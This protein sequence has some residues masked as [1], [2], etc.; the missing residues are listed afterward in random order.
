MT[1][2][3]HLILGL[4]AAVFIAEPG[5]ALGQQ[6]DGEVSSAPAPPEPPSAPMAGTVITP[7]N[8]TTSSDPETGKQKDDAVVPTIRFNGSNATRSSAHDVERAA[9]SESVP[10][11]S[12]V[13]VAANVPAK[14]AEPERDSLV[15]LTARMVE[16]ADV[17]AES[18]ELAP[19]DIQSIDPCCCP[20]CRPLIWLA[21]V[22]ATFLWPD[23]N[24]DDAIFEFEDDFRDIDIS[25]SSHLDG[26]DSMYLT[27]RL[28][29]G[30]QG[31]NWGTNVRYW[32]LR[33]AGG[34]FDPTLDNESDDWSHSNFDWD[35]TPD[36]GFFTCSDLDAYTID[37]ELTR[38]FCLGNCAS[39]ASF[40]VRYGSVDVNNSI[41][42]VALDDD[43]R[44]VGY[45]RSNAYTRGTGVVMGLYGRKPLFP[46]SCV[47]WYYNARWSVMWGPTSTSAETFASVMVDGSNAGSVNG[48]STYVDDTLFIGEIQ[49]GLEWNY[50][51]QCLPA[52]AF[53]RTA[54]EYQRWDGGPGSSE[55]GSFASLTDTNNYTSTASVF[56]SAHSPQLDLLGL[57]FGTGLTW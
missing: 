48:A 49:L 22:E 10:R 11:K 39:Q 18:S 5:S 8:Q 57:T 44:H 31:C 32:H 51:L 26:V 13:I 40:G 47:H 37:W 9:V 17:P 12:E 25:H 42:G 7:S 35:A 14:S 21:G 27:P 29:L 6:L 16:D 53:F 36:T 55:A 28:W 19:A 4:L 50:A 1:C 38:R 52:N 45:A 43:A 54:L 24:D 30:V 56:T 34:V 33:A 15:E 23:A 3:I 2:R 46:C 41:T 20:P